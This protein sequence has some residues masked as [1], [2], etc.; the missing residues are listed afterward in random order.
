MPKLNLLKNV[1]KMIDEAENNIGLTFT[2]N[3][4]L[5]KYEQKRNPRNN[6]QPNTVQQIQKRSKSLLKNGMI[7]TKNITRK[8][9]DWL[10][11]NTR[12]MK[13]FVRLVGKEVVNGTKQTKRKLK[14]TNRTT[15]I[16]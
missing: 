12:R 6:A 16:F 11:K 13:S 10:G 4:A 7:H 9:I 5:T 1:Q 2:K 3:C 14:N 8:R 15:K